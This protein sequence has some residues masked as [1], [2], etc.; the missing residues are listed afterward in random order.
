MS[1]TNCASKE[2]YA[3]LVDLKELNQ[4]A[5][6]KL[7]CWAN[8]LLHRYFVCVLL[9]FVRFLVL[10]SISSFQ[11]AHEQKVKVKGSCWPSKKGCSN[12]KNGTI[13]KQTSMQRYAE[14]ATKLN[15]EV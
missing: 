9:H 14:K 15:F 10:Y 11:V 12:L 2:A 7:V 6:S 4:S 1:L 3:A 13:P 8:R 5:H